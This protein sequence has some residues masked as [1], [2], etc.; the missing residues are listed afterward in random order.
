ML[1]YK[2]KVTRSGPITYYI[3]LNGGKTEVEIRQLGEGNDGDIIVT[4]RGLKKTCSLEETADQFK[5]N[6]NQLS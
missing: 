3:S 2:V 5:V 6:L 1:I 4:Y